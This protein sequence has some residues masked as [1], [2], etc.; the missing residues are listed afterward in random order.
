MSGVLYCL[1]LL[2]SDYFCTDGVWIAPIMY[3]IYEVSFE[4]LYYPLDHFVLYP[5]TNQEQVEYSI[6]QKER[7]RNFE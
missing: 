2:L 4:G 3:C 7:Q 1:Q 5:T 6:V